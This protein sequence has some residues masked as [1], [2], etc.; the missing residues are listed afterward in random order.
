MDAL[1]VGLAIGLA[2][3]VSPGPL[4]VLVITQTLRSGWRAGVLAACAPLASDLIV[5]TGVLLVLDHLPRR[6]VDVL[7][8]V[9]GVVIAALGARTVVEARSASIAVDAA[10]GPRGWAVADLRRAAVGEPDQPPPVDL[11]GG[12]PGATGDHDVAGVGPGAVA[13]VAGFYVTLIGAKMTLAGLVDRGRRTGRP[14][15]PV[16][17]P[18][19]AALLVIAGGALVLEFAPKL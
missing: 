17:A 1:L 19:A 13:L 11:V 2:A 4:L 3:G 5:V 18:G 7:G 12:R 16:R 14:R 9:G 15:V 10:G 6:T 8:V